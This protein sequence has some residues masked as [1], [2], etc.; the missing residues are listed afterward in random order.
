MNIDFLYFALAAGLGIALLAGPLGSLMVWQ[1]MA[2]FGDTLA[3]GALLG[4]AIGLWLSLSNDLAVLLTCLG[5]AGLLIV[6]QELHLL[7]TDTLLGIL[8]HTALALGLVAL[9]LIPGARVNM[10][11]L[12]FGDL[13]AI[14]KTEVFTIWVLAGLVLAGLGYWWRQLVAVTVHEDLAQVEG[15]PVRRVKTM[16]KLMLATV[17]AVGMKVAGVL[18]ITALLI[19]PA[20]SARRFSHNPEQMAI[21]G[22]VIAALAVLLG[23]TASWFLDTPAGPSIVLAG[24][25]L[26][27]AASLS[28]KAD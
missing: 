9:A 5:L 18:L 23:L 6:L 15:V 12:L 3:H 10:E 17:V 21:L 16:Q 24:G 14:S 2:Y 22:S 13:L 4:V 19:I 25:V 8:S 11:G 7:A 20:A 1:R 26:F 28:P 27:G